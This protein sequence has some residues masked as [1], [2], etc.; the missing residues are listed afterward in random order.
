MVFHLPNVLILGTHHCGKELQ[1][2]FKC[3]GEL[4]DILCWRDYAERLV[5]IFITKYNLDNMVEIYQ[6][7]LK[8]SN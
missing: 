8:A 2:E 3:R 4:H 7:I 1:K 5:S 6:Y